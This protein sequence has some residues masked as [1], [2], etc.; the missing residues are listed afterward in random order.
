M[1]TNPAYIIMPVYFCYVHMTAA[2]QCDT[3][4]FRA[5]FHVRMYGECSVVYFN[6][7]ML[8]LNALLKEATCINIQ[9]KDFY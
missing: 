6:D 9:S 8:D 4:T 2:I 5:C 7:H 1:E 3:A